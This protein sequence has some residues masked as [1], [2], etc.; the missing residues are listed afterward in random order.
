VIAADGTVAKV[1][2][3]VDAKTHA[4][5]VLAVLAAS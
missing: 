3:K 1:M 2:R 5:D 4:D